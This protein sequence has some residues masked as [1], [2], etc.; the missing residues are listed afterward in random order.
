MASA[1]GAFGVLVCSEDGLGESSVFNRSGA[2]SIRG[3][4]IML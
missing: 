2:A 1:D 4:T 3:S